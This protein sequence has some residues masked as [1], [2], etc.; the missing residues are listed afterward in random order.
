MKA[1]SSSRTLLRMIGEPVSA[2][3]KAAFPL[4]SRSASINACLSSA[5]AGALIRPSGQTRTLS[6]ASLKTTNSP[7][8]T[9]RRRAPSSSAMPAQSSSYSG[10]SISV[11][12]FSV[13]NPCAHHRTLQEG[14]SVRGV[15]LHARCRHGALESGGVVQRRRCE[16]LAPAPAIAR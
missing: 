8:S 1:P 5:G 13:C 3:L 6:M 16:C 2:C 10:V 11:Y 4:P 15:V 12:P 9:C 7:P 14:E